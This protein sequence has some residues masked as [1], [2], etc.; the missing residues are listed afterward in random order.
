MIL[1]E[2]NQM[3]LYYCSP[4][5]LSWGNRTGSYCVSRIAVTALS[6]LPFCSP[7]VT[8]SSSTQPALLGPLRPTSSMQPSLSMPHISSSRISVTPL[9]QAFH[10]SQSC[11]LCSYQHSARC[12]KSPGL[13]TQGNQPPHTLPVFGW[14]GSENSHKLKEHLL[15]YAAHRPRSW[16]REGPGEQRAQAL[17]RPS[18]LLTQSPPELHPVGNQGRASHTHRPCFSS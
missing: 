3:I 15:R 6:I 13:M 7:S 14:L 1:Q 8:H 17:C 5:D 9:H 4:R 11:W 12:L 10:H 16:D 18:A 2:T